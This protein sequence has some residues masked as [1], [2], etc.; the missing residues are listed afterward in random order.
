MK[1]RLLSMLMLICFGWL[2]WLQTFAST[3]LWVFPDAGRQPLIQAINQAKY[4]VDLV[5][6]GFTDKKLFA[7]LQAAKK[8]GIH[9]RVLLQKK[10]YKAVN[11]NVAMVANIKANQIRLQWSNPKFMITHQKTLIID[12]KLAVIMTFNFT[13]STFT[14][15]R[16]FALA[17]TN[18]NDIKEIM[19]VF[20]ADWNR[21]SVTVSQTN[22]VWSPINAQAKIVN[23]IDQSNNKLWVYNQE[24]S[25]F[26]VVGALARAQRR[27]VAVQVILPYMNARA[28]CGKLLY[29][30]KNGVAVRLDKKLYIH[31]KAM[32]YQQKDGSENSFVGSM[33]FSPSGLTRNR[34]LGM[35][36]SDSTVTKK[37]RQTFAHDWDVSK[38]LSDV[39]DDD[40]Y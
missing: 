27:G 39:C 10:P 33:N 2:L 20:N 12:H 8:R 23:F 3:Q 15:E 37:L 29:L 6:Y 32:L 7:A 40:S 36:T 25:S 38:P 35:L 26:A 34:E 11:E 28:Y 13:A 4:S 21:Q 30:A 31:A 1:K 9:V 22:L 24:M 18:K 19:T 16:N 17:T 14:K 5:I